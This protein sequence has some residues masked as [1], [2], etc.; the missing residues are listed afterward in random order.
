MP[1]WPFSRVQT[2]RPLGFF[3]RQDDLP[4][5]Q[6]SALVEGRQKVRRARLEERRAV[7]GM[8]AFYK[9]KSLWSTVFCR[10]PRWVSLADNT[11]SILQDAT[12]EQEREIYEAMKI[13]PKGY[14]F[15]PRFT[16]HIWDG[17]DRFYDLV[18]HRMLTGLVLYSQQL[19]FEY[20]EIIQASNPVEEYCFGWQLYVRNR[21]GNKVPV[22][23]NKYQDAGVAEI[24]QGVRRGVFDH[25]TGAGKSLTIAA[26]CA[27]LGTLQIL[28]VVP[29]LELLDQTIEGLET[30]LPE[31]IGRLGGKRK[32][33]ADARIV[34]AFDLT[35]KQKGKHPVILDL[36]A[37][38]QVLI[39]DE[40]QT[41]TKLLYPFFRKCVNAYFRFGFS[42]S[43]YDID[44]ARVLSVAGFFGPTITRVT[45]VET[46][47][48]GRTVPPHFTYFEYPIADEREAAYGTVYENSLVENAAFNAY[49]AQQ[50]AEPYEAG[51]TILVLVQRL[52]HCTNFQEALRLLGIESQIYTGQVNT[53]HRRT[54][55][56]QFKAGKLP[57]LV[58]TEKT[59]GVGVDLPCMDLLLNLGGGQ[60]ASMSKQKF[61]R[62]FRS[63]EGKEFV[64]VYE[65][66]ITIHRWFLRHSK[67]RLELAKAYAG[68]VELKYRSGKVIVLK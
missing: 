2:S 41:V 46:Q 16:A 17:Y 50:L 55:R 34:V 1:V 12:P 38:C 26:I 53:E 21:E 3:W 13:R 31:P 44:F 66:Y 57:V 40:I 63:F 19:G 36:A 47:A 5:W 54:M 43:F 28:I 4:C 37:R 60:S 6:T 52:N 7:V 8:S 45:D 64:R 10:M 23:L 68:K 42:G 61:G 14:F 15:D 58:A 62:S 51:E 33:N 30:A 27:L 67:A 48:E 59:L 22:E 32:Q 29:S 18:K 39:V 24:P 9:D 56:S 11:W 20:E 49:M 65:P 35:L 25:S